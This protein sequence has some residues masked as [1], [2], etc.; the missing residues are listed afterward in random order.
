MKKRDSINLIFRYSDL[1]KN[2]LLKR[3][4]TDIRMLNNFMLSDYEFQG[5]I[6]QYVTNI[7]E[8]SKIL[9]DSTKAKIVGVDWDG[10]YRARNIIAHDYKA[11]STTV[12]SRLVM[13][14]ILP[15]RDQLSHI[16]S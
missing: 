14:S 9:D 10:L 5:F 3:G 12:I 6:F 16:I 13:R 11:V 2:S 7:G 1:V 8:L 15:L 4:I